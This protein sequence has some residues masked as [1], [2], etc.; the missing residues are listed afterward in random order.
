AAVVFGI[1]ATWGT[2]VF[3]VLTGGGFTDPESE[4]AIALE[5]IAEEVGTQDSHLAVIYSSPTATVDDPA[6]AG[7]VTDRVAALRASPLVAEVQSWYDTGSPA[8]VSQDRHATLVT[9]RVAEVGDE[10]GLLARFREVRPLL[11]APEVTTQ[12][13]GLA[14]FYDQTVTQTERD[15][16]RA[17]AF[18]FPILLVLLALIF[19]GV[20]AAVTPLLI[21]GLAILGGFMTTRLLAA[22]TEMS[23]FAVNIITVIGLGLA[24]DYSLLVVNRFREELDAGHAPARAVGRTLAT[25]GRAVLVSGL[26]TIFALL[27]LLIF[28]QAYLRSMALGGIAAI[29]VAMLGTLTVLPA[30]LAVL[31]HR[32]NAGRAPLPRWRRRSAAAAA[33]QGEREGGWAR[34]A[35]AVMRRPLPYL[36]VTVAVLLL[37]ASPAPRAEF[38][39][40]DE[41][42]LPAGAESRVVAERIRDDFP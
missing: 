20:V 38:G 28:P 25:A 16:V 31:G 40:F 9:G 2:G 18:S 15:I 1:G 5:R 21:G 23:I 7:P 30:L 4:S 34:A 17:E 26:T 39:G 41:R 12:I 37:L 3:G 14:A 33:G 35:R 19:R 10:D 29:A 27:S 36:L 22:V 42:E 13:G 11:T 24:I 8:L 6:L 32:V